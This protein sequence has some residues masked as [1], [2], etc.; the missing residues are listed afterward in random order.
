[1]RA[2]E[3]VPIGT[4]AVADDRRSSQRAVRHTAC[5]RKLFSARPE[6]AKPVFF[7][8]LMLSGPCI[9]ELNCIM[10]NVMHK[11]LIYISI[12]FRLIVWFGLSFNPSSEAGVQLP[13][14]F[15]S[16]GYGVSAR[17]LTP[18]YPRDLNHCRICASACED[19][20]KESPKRVRQKY[21]YKFI[22]MLCITLFV[23]KFNPKMHGP[24]NIKKT[25]R[26]FHCPV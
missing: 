23:I 9:L 10:T 3:E 1:M 5:P 15:K 4:T 20:L 2:I 8:Y 26:D 11:F 19:G 14:W 6:V 25:Y 24:Y 21:I 7:F 22:K 12:Y 17:A 16:P 13:Q 18:S